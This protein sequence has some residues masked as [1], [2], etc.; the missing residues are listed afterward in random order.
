MKICI[1]VKENNGLNS[2]AYNHFGS[3]PFFLIYNIEND[4]IKVIENKNLHHS[5]G[6][7]Q[8]LKAVDGEDIDTVLVGGIGA[9]A[10]MKLKDQGIRV[11]KV[12]DESVSKNIELLRSNEL[13]EFTTNNSC[14][15]HDCGH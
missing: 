12:S 4:E 3:A 11:F 2:T 1:P 9:R 8:P 10:L 15:S 13:D 6:M 5:H 7:C 14:T